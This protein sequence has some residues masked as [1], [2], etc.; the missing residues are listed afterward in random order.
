MLDG[1][2]V[3]EETTVSSSSLAHFAPSISIDLLEE[4]LYHDAEVYVQVPSRGS[5]Y[6]VSRTRPD[7]IAAN[8]VRAAARELRP[9]G[10]PAC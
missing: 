8:R 4:D 7:A 1:A 2:L 3:L 9:L 10:S 5:F 6:C